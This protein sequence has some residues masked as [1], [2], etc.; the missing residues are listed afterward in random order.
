ML[1]SFS[2]TLLPALL[3]FQF[4]E[5]LWHQSEAGSL[6]RWIYQEIYSLISFIE[7]QCK[8]IPRMCLLSTTACDVGFFLS[9]L[10]WN[11]E[12]ACMPWVVVIIHLGIRSFSPTTLWQGVF[13]PFCDFF[14]YFTA[15]TV[16]MHTPL[17]LPC[18]GVQGYSAV[19]VT[20][21]SL[22]SLSEKRGF[23]CMPLVEQTFPDFQL[24]P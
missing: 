23:K 11:Y 13:W 8:W 5:A 17:S 10:R 19:K 15:R 14:L 24:H 21:P 1:V 2:T 7:E 16:W 9:R 4:Q 22:C 18:S 20:Q 6:P 12:W 3:T